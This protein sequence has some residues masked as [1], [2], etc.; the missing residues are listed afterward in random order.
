MI[1]EYE[2]VFT[3]NGIT[4]VF[5][6]SYDECLKIIESDSE[7]KATFVIISKQSEP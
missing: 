4:R 7:G 2:L 5:C 6:G 3:E 1:E